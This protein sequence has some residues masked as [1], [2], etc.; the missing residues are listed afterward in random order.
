MALQDRLH[1]DAR[2]ALVPAVR[3]VFRALR[4]RGVPVCVSGA[5]P[6]LLA[7][8]PDGPV[9]DPGDGWRVLEPGVRP[10]GFEVSSLRLSERSGRVHVPVLDRCRA[11]VGPCDEAARPRWTAIA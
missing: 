6:T 7:F 2:L 11:P 8:E 4:D 1:Q 9:A 5:G 10:R 3:E